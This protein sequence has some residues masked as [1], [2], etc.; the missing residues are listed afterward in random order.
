M[1]PT[2][3]RHDSE[4]GTKFT[5]L[6][7]KNG[8]VRHLN[9]AG[10]QS[11]VSLGKVAKWATPQARD[12]RTGSSARWEDA[13]KGYRSCNLNDQVADVADQLN[14]DWVEWLM[15]WPIGWT[16]LQP[17]PAQEWQAW[18][19]HVGSSWWGHDPADSGQIPRIAN[20]IP[21]RVSRI[22]AI[23]NGQVPC[24]AAAAWQMLVEGLA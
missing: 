10:K 17:L 11:R 2:S 8:T 19:N 7:T 14:P 1:W 24:V 21:K 23:G 6:L 18:M 12:Y 3:T 4:A 15:N 5:P 22:R 16:S 9:K 20:G 13:R